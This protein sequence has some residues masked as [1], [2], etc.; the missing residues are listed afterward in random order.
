MKKEASSGKLSGSIHKKKSAA[1]LECLAQKLG[2]KIVTRSTS[3]AR[4][5]QLH[6]SQLQLNNAIRDKNST[7]NIGCNE[8]LGDN[9]DFSRNAVFGR[10]L[11]DKQILPL[12]IATNGVPD[13]DAAPAMPFRRRSL[14]ANTQILGRSN[15]PQRSRLTLPPDKIPE[16]SSP[17]P[18]SH[19]GLKR[20]S[21]KVMASPMI[22]S[23]SDQNA[24]APPRRSLSR[25]APDRRTPPGRTS[26][27]LSGRGQSSALFNHVLS[28]SSGPLPPQRA[29]SFSK[30]R[31]SIGYDDIS[32]SG[33][34]SSVS[35]DPPLVSS[36]S[37]P[38]SP[39]SSPETLPNSFCHLSKFEKTLLEANEMVE[40]APG[41]N[42]KVR[43]AKETWSCLQR[44]F[45]LPVTCKV[46]F[47]ELTCI[48]DL[49]HVLCPSCSLVSPLEGGPK[50]ITRG[51]GVGLGFTFD[52][53]RR[54]EMFSRAS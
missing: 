44:D 46:C 12:P 24:R 11:P 16:T 31:R 3:R 1:K 34:I 45:Y 7:K 14:N 41:V 52:D 40:V 19:R 20:H 30:P 23:P 51:G 48:R 17:V 9:G 21:S 54:W 43:G 37:T 28:E 13:A 26:S 18:P 33:D 4:I 53:L 27:F 49:D 42:A 8:L 50:G 47:A 2:R 10:I 15:S 5:S 6:L 35:N 29:P 22:Q 25:R 38:H 32:S 39:T 36:S